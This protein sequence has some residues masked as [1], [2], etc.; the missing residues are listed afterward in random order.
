MSFNANIPAAT[1]KPSQSQAQILANFG[2]L[3]TVFAVDHLAFNAVDG[4]EHEK[5]TLN[6]PLG[7]DPGAGGTKSS[8]YS[9]TSGATQEL[10]FEN[11]ALVSQLTGLTTVAAANGYIT[12][13]GGIIIKWGT[14]TGST[15]GVANIFPVAF[16][17]NCWNVQ[18]IT[19]ATK[20]VVG[21]TINSRTTFT[22]FTDGATNIYYIAIG[23]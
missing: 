19:R 21:V 22:A 7:A 4:G 16:P 1:D 10:F 12:L 5:V 6:A 20:K 3:N 23:N 13:Q 2:A 15:A 17:T 9:K 14:G 18:I 8:I 11:S